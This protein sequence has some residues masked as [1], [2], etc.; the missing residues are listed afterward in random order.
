MTTKIVKEVI[1]QQVLGY[2]IDSV[3]LK[4]TVL[5]DDNTI[6]YKYVERPLVKL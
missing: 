4:L 2:G 6:G 1:S 5:Y 3:Y